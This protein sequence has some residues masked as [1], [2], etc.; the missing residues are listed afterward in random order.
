[1]SLYIARATSLMIANQYLESHDMWR[2]VQY[3]MATYS[4]NRH[5]YITTHMLSYVS[6]WLRLLSVLRVLGPLMLTV[7]VSCELIDWGENLYQ[8]VSIDACGTS[9][10]LCAFTMQSCGRCVQ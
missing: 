10:N 8:Q 2:Y 5:D 1:M 4:P 6:R 7:C 3:E 9:A